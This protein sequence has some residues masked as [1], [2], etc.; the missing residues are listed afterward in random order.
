MKRKR[1]SVEQIV[2]VVRQHE[3]G[4]SAAD[5]ARKLGNAEQVFYRRKKKYGG[6]SLGKIMR[7]DVA[8][9]MGAPPRC[10]HSV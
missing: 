8:S 1:Y 2:A 5:I 6:W 7:W 10:C 4:G 9:N 3:L